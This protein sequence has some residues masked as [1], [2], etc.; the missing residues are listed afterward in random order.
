MLHQEPSSTEQ[1]VPCPTPATPTA[2]K[3]HPESVA[4]RVQNWGF[5]RRLVFTEDEDEDGAAAEESS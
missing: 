1:A 4:Y 3:R 5:K 2:A